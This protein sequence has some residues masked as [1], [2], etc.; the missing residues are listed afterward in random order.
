MGTITKA[1]YDQLWNDHHGRSIRTPQPDFKEFQ[2]SE[3]ML[4]DYLDIFRGRNTRNGTI[5]MP[6]DHPFF[7][8]EGKPILPGLPKICKIMVGEA[9]L[10]PSVPVLNSCTPLAGDINNT[11]FYDI[12]HV[13]SSQPWLN[14]V[15]NYCGCPNPRPC[16]SNKVS[17]L[18]C[19][20]SQGILLLDLFPFAIIYTPNKRKALNKRGTT[21][22]FWNDLSNPY[23][24]ESR[25]NKLGDLLC[26]NWD[27]ALVAPCIISN[28]VVG[29]LPT[30]SVTP[31]GKHPAV[32][33][34]KLFHPKRCVRTPSQDLLKVAVA[35]QGPSAELLKAAFG[36]DPC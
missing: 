19:L 7:T 29:S 21:V 31:H 28:H 11:Y 33:K 14:A 12:R 30:L 24:L 17:T 35:Q 26:P 32:F 9:R 6:Y 25:L 13:K 20:A 23:S 3:R 16:P 34:D 4:Q 22:S 5:E 36:S 2:I 15:S 10:P 27:L 1:Q 18:L 8:S